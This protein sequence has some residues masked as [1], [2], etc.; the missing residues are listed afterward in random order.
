MSSRRDDD[1]RY[2][3]GGGGGGGYRGSNYS[4]SSSSNNNYGGG[5]NSY[6]GGG[7]GDSRSSYRGGGGGYRHDDRR[8]NSDRGYQGGGGGGGRGRDRD[9]ERDRYGGG[10]DRGFWG[11]S[12]SRGYG[13]DRGG[14][15]YGGGRD[16]GRGDYGGR[17]GGGGGG[18]RYNRGGGG[19]GCRTVTEHLARIHGTEEDKVNCPFYFKIGACRHGDRCSRK[20]NVPAFSQTILVEH[21][22]ENKKYGR[23]T[24]ERAMTEKDRYMEKEEFYDFY[25]DIFLEA[26]RFGKLERVVVCDNLGDHMVGH[27]YIKFEDEEVRKTDIDFRFGRLVRN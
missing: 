21:C 14:G 3:G 1:R 13:G 27:I 20:H 19:P 22:W 6:R 15:G 8:G 7:G 9:R 26:A 5:G 17:R 18:G 4:S 10:G 24:N 11:G 12:G 25:E 23:E 2:Q 16:Y